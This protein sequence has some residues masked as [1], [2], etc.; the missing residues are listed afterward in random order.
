MIGNIHIPNHARPRYEFL[1]ILHIKNILFFAI[2]S[3]LKWE[4][5]R[6]K[7]VIAYLYTQQFSAAIFRTQI[8]IIFCIEIVY[9]LW[10]ILENFYSNRTSRLRE[11]MILNFL[12]P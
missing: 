9:N 10:F 2:F 6:T 5:A 8:R 4:Y 12:K 1:K 3:L 11:I 7:C